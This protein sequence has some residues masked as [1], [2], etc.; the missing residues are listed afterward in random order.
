MSERR[1]GH[2]ALSQPLVAL[3]FCVHRDFRQHFKRCAVEA[4]ITQKELLYQA[5]E[6]WEQLHGPAAEQ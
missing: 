4:E 1:N 6:A 5:L 3:N 2:A